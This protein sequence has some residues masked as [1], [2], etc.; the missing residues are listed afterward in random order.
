MPGES[1]IVP[2][3]ST[4]SYYRARYYDPN[5]A[6][7]LR[8]DPIRWWGGIDFYTYGYNR[9][10]NMVDRFGLL[11]SK[12]DIWKGVK[13][14]WNTAQDAWGKTKGIADKI[15]CIFGCINCVNPA[16]E[17]SKAIGRAQ[18]G[19]PPVYLPGDLANQGNPNYVGA[20]LALEGVRQIQMAAQENSNCKDCIQNCLTAVPAI[21]MLPQAPA[22]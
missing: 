14:A 12:D 7:F 20:P 15:G 16:C 10:T 2:V 8:E 6:R 21:G 22:P 18:G 9:P 19:G 11:P 13:S 17:N 4:E 1:Q 3:A 5:V